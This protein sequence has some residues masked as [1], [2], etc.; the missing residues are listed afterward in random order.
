MSFYKL[1]S[2]SEQ[3]LGEL[4]VAENPSKYLYNKYKN[5][6][7]KEQDIL[8]GIIKELR[9]NGY[10]DVIWADSCPVRVNLNNSARTYQEQ[11]AEYERQTQSFQSRSTGKKYTNIERVKELIQRGER[12]GKEE[13]HPADGGFPF[14]YVDGPQCDQWMN[15]IKTFNERYLQQHPLYK[16]INETFYRY[17]REDS[18]FDTMMGYLRALADDEEFWETSELMEKTNMYDVFISH[19]SKDK[20]DYV[21]KLKESLDKL[22]VKV[23][24]DKDTIEWGDNWK[25][26]IMEGVQKA[27]F[28]I[29][30]ISEN[31]FGREWTEL[32]L[33]EFLHRQNTTGQK[34]ILPI[35]YNI[36]DKQLKDK[37]P[38]VADIQGLK[39][40]EHS[41]DEITLLFARQ[42]IKRLKSKKSIV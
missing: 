34:I 18:A 35:F 37:Y 17:K 5:A 29:I 14:S 28:A 42:L 25:N 13:Y 31:F 2:N 16:S 3:L 4:V 6:N 33:D 15:E 36:T 9:E 10:I 21:D 19:A 11:L 24:Y 8:R 32:E 7:S 23:F 39:S 38:E 40:S 1:P 27:E 22:G 41:C 12:I 26:N 20:L 30:V